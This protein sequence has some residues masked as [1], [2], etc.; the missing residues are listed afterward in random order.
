[1]DVIGAVARDAHVL[2]RAANKLRAAPPPRS[3][4]NEVPL[5][6]V[7]RHQDLVSTIL[8]R[9]L[10]G[11]IGSQIETV[12]GSLREQHTGSQQ[13]LTLLEQ[14]AAA[15]GNRCAALYAAR[16]KHRVPLLKVSIIVR[17]T[18]HHGELPCALGQDRG[19]WRQQHG[20]R[21]PEPGSA[22]HGHGRE[23]FRFSNS[24]TF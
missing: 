23:H 11:A 16:G 20:H 3:G 17:G 8:D 19:H 18:E 10:E 12:F 14:G 7:G 5:V 9:L 13:A 1:M 15:V 6:S 22:E 21:K 4:A 2:S 24:N